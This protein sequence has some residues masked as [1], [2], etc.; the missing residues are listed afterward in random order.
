MS[1]LGFFKATIENWHKLEK[2]LPTRTKEMKEALRQYE[3]SKWCGDFEGENEEDIKYI[4]EEMKKI[5][6]ELY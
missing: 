6:K 2:R 4:D 3:L 1:C 5:Y